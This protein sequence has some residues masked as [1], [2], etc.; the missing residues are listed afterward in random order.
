[1]GRT[2]RDGMDATAGLNCAECSRAAEESDYKGAILLRCMEQG[3]RGVRGRVVSRYP[4]GYR[5]AEICGAPAWC[6][7]RK[8]DAGHQKNGV[9]PAENAAS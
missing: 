4:E 7:R 9:D 2:G 8:D 5:E 1:M 3:L 6:E